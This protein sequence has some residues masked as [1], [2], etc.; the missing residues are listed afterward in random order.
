MTD[1]RAI[2]NIQGINEALLRFNPGLNDARVG[3]LGGQKY[4]ESII[5]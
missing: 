4:G 3:R 1:R 2:H 5:L